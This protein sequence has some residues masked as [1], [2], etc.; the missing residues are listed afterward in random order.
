MSAPTLDA[1]RCQH[2][3]AQADQGEPKLGWHLHGLGM[4]HY[5]AG[6]F[7]EAIERLHES[8]N[9]ALWN[10]SGYLGNWVA[11]ARLPQAGTG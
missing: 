7:E 3:A 9:K 10:D 6:Q 8:N 11:L 1:E 5:R 4:A 2:L